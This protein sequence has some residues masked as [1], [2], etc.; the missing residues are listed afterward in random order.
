MADPNEFTEAELL[1]W[2][3]DSIRTKSNIFGYGYQGHVYLYRRNGQ[4]LIVKAPTGSFLTRPIRRAMVRNEHR[5]YAKLA[6]LAGVPRCYGLLAGSYLVLEYIDGI[7]IRQATISDHDAFFQSLLS[8][9]KNLHKAGV[10]H[11]DLKKKDNL[12]VVDG[13]TPYLIDF[14]A[15]VI[16][17]GRFAP[18]NRYL[19]AMARRFDFNAW[20]KL[21]YDGD[22]DTM[23]KEDERY[24]RRT[25]LEKFARWVKRHYLKG[26][27][28]LLRRNSLLHY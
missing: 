28:A 20:A 10:A 6:G 3:R 7:P 9:I 5:A 2:V 27:H 14:G 16:R 4:Q 18:L 12:L 22:F 21:K 24:Y 13:C 23:T 1:E 25:I 15:A 17:K 19:Y 8:L 26:K 11:A